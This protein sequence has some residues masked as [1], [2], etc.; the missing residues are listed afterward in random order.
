[1]QVNLIALKA[2]K[3]NYHDARIFEISDQWI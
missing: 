1:L 2:N 3:K